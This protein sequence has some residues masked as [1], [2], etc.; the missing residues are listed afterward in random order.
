M[1]QNLQANDRW[2]SNAQIEQ[3]GEE[4]DLTANIWELRARYLQT[5]NM[6]W[7]HVPLAPVAN[8]VTN[9]PVG[10][11]RKLL[12]RCLQYAAANPGLNLDT[13]HWHLIIHSQNFQHP[14]WVD[15]NDDVRAVND[16]RNNVADP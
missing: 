7:S 10:Q 1:Y 3:L 15:H 12:T 9:W 14:P 6:D 8:S 4:D 16:L 11:D 13:S 2:D 5:D